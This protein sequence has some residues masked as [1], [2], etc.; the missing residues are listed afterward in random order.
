MSP[1]PTLV[2]TVDSVR[3]RSAQ[4]LVSLWNP[5]NPSLRASLT[6]RLGA[7][8]GEGDALLASPV[9]EARF[10]Y[11]RVPQTLAELAEAGFPSAKLVAAMHN[12]PKGSEE[13]QFPRDRRPYGH[14]VKAWNALRA[15]KSVVVATGTGSGKT[16]CFLVP[17]LDDA[18]REAEQTGKAVE[19]VQ[20]LLLYPLNALIESQR[21]R[22]RAWTHAF[23]GKVRYALYNGDTPNGATAAARRATPEEVIDRQALRESPPP[24]LVTNATMLEYMLVRPED[25]PILQKSQGKLRTIVLDE[26]HTY[27]GSRAAEVAL[28]LRRVLLAFGVEPKDVRFVATSATIGGADAEMQLKDFLATVSGQAAEDITV[29]MGAPEVRPLDGTPDD[30]GK[31]ELNALAALAPIERYAH[32]SR[33]AKAGEIRKYIAAHTC[34]L[35]DLAAETMG[36]RTHATQDWL[37][38]FLDLAIE[39]KSDTSKDAESFLPVRAH[40]FVRTPPGLWACANPE[41]GKK[42]GLD[43]AWP[44]GAVY[45]SPRAKCECMGL[46]YPLA[47]CERCGGEYLEAVDETTAYRPPQTH[48]L[49][50]VEDRGAAHDGAVDGADAEG[51]PEDES[52]GAAED[53]DPHALATSPLTC[54]IRRVRPGEEDADLQIDPTTGAYAA[55][56]T[57]RMVPSPLALDGKAS[58]CVCCGHP[59]RGQR[60]PIRTVRA[61]TPFMLRTVLPIVLAELPGQGDTDKPHGGRRLLSFTDSRQGSARFAVAQQSESERAFLRGHL[62]QRAWAAQAVA[63]DVVA[64]QAQIAEYEASL[65][66]PLPPAA[67]TA[68]EQQLAEE[69]KKLEPQVFGVSLVKIANLLQEAPEHVLLMSDRRRFNGFDEDVGIDGFAK[70]LLL[71]ELARKPLKSRSIEALGLVSLRYPKLARA[72]A[73]ACW[74]QL[75]NEEG[76]VADASWRD[77][78]K[79]VID[80]HVRQAMG[81]VVDRAWLRWMGIRFPTVILA[82]PDR[83]GMIVRQSGIVKWPM[84]RAGRR[85]HQVPRLLFRA[86][87]LNPEVKDH[88]EAVNDIMEAAWIALYN[89]NA[90][91]HVLTPL[92]GGAKLDLL[93]EAE[94]VPTARIWQCPITR[95]ALDTV[96]RGCSPYEDTGVVTP[97]VAYD[98]PAAP[99]KFDGNPADVRAWTQTSP[100][101][102]VLRAVGLWTDLHDNIVTS[103]QLF[104]VREHSAQVSSHQLEE[105]VNAFKV[106]GVNVLSCSTTMEMGVDIGSL[107]AVTMNNVPPGAANYRQR[108]GRAGRRAEPLALAL[109]VARALPHDTMVFNDPTWAFTSTMN[110]PKAA[111]DREKIVRRHVHARILNAFLL[112]S[113]FDHRL[114]CGG[115]FV[116]ATATP[117]APTEWQRF[118][119][120]LAASARNDEALVSHLGT[121]VH[122]TALEGSTADALLG[123]AREAFTHA[124][125][126]VLAELDAIDKE[127]AEIGDL[128]P[129]GTP[130]PQWRAVRNRRKRVYG[131]YLLSFFAQAQV[132]PGHGTAAGVV[133]FVTTTLADLLRRADDGQNTQN[134]RPERTPGRSRDYPSYASPLALRAYAPGNVVVVDGLAYTSRGITLSW[135]LPVGADVAEVQ[136]LKSAYHCN[137]CG[138]TEVH[139]GIAARTCPDDH[140]VMDKTDFLEPDGFAVDIY[141]KPSNDVSAATWIPVS[142]PRISAHNGT[143]SNV[144][145]FVAARHDPNGLLFHESR[146]TYGHGYSLCLQCGRAAAISHV[147]QTPAEMVDHT[148]LRGGKSNDQINADN[149]CLGNASLHTRN[150]G[151]AVNTDV[152]ELRFT[153][154]SENLRLTE[155]AVATT[156]AVALRDAL[157]EE[158]DVEAAELGH[159]IHKLQ[160]GTYTVCL[161]D[162][163]TGGAGFVEEAPRRLRALVEAVYQ[164]LNGCSCDRACERCLVGAETQH[165]LRYLNRKETLK[166]LTPAL[167]ESLAPP[168]DWGTDATW[169]WRT[170]QAS[171]ASRLRGGAATVRL[172]CHGEE[173]DWDLPAWTDHPVLA[174]LRKSDTRVEIAFATGAVDALDADD[175]KLLLGMRDTLGW[176]IVEGALPPTFVWAEVALGARVDR[177]CSE[178]HGGSFHEA[179]L[180]G[181][182]AAEAGA[183]A[184]TVRRGCRTVATLYE[185]KRVSNRRLESIPEGQYV[186]VTFAPKDVSG[187]LQQVMKKTFDRLLVEA[188]TVFAGITAPA[189]T[190][191]VYDRYL[192]SPQNVGNLRAIVRELAARNWVAGG[193][194][195]IVVHSVSALPPKNG[196]YN[197]GA[198]HND[199]TDPQVQAR[200]LTAALEEFGAV[201]VRLVDAPQKMQHHRELRLSWQNGR[202]ASVRLDQGC[203]FLRSAQH[204]PTGYD[205]ATMLRVVRTANW[206]ATAQASAD[207]VFY[208]GRRG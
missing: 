180:A 148:R 195:K 23:K 200:T 194:T 83:A 24:L 201:D 53:D 35:T 75:T 104:L 153:E 55:G 21:D 150:L 110:V 41:C 122:R 203:S 96:L 8:P 79:L 69:R 56:S 61:G 162:T 149:R 139:R 186:E 48:V 207:T 160:D 63:V 190:L 66:F 202:T 167:R 68:V 39:A 97:C 208:L 184:P 113:N 125:D 166:F 145:D 126:R 119:D 154:P 88:R 155:R 178:G 89:G 62:L 20:T 159:G 100:E 13:Q 71:R 2:S 95:G 67:R 84:A 138:R 3:D 188:T 151:V 5:A 135:H 72:A 18:V 43:A 181:P 92:A 29:C 128:P 164:R 106:G 172:W 114:T 158:L 28:L 176:E 57:H 1:T 64:I 156:L 52:E 197:S 141:E 26:A 14:Q 187:L 58:A 50:L 182:P 102:Q 32:L 112:A 185:V 19:G 129:N 183:Q 10:G 127:L 168:V 7:W 78:L 131:E 11:D 42:E 179:W 16:E 46:V 177:L 171:L 117:N 60:A 25:A 37:L 74:N 40:L 173:G 134:T 191:T 111:L 130:S 116:A 54:W 189:A 193:T 47:G 121:L 101:V 98:V 143:W 109:T 115:F 196:Y 103:P 82:P 147:G 12:V 174:D 118:Q 152:V 4:A 91:G 108:A 136:N 31:P 70:L 142:P 81:L 192:K 146:G 65:A 76:S 86:Y 33:L 163:A 85:Q 199:W 27:L 59:A 170:P 90:D 165:A 22:L 161:Y 45:L 124:S 34:T 99:V 49:A 120:W 137:M 206:Q 77:F 123:A 132:L 198:L 140:T 144:G 15:N 105:A 157:A 204:V 30:D 80:L 205:E 51:W 9:L 44:F 17:T 94:V 175:K 169:E 6:A 73:P 133:P 107:T 87:G 36:D 93:D 38:R